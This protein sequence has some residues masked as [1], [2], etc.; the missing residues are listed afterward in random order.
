VV[1]V[2]SCPPPDAGDKLRGI[3]SVAGAALSHPGADDLLATVGYAEQVS[4]RPP[5]LAYADPSYPGEGLAV[6]G[7]P[8][9]GE[10]DHAALIAG[11]AE[12]DGWA[13]SISAE[14]LPAV[15]VCPPEGP[16]LRLLPAAS[17]PPGGLQQ[18]KNARVRRVRDGRR[19]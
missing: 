15:L 17:A 7:S 10:V 2:P 1:V 14:A 8:D 5:R 4:G 18:R 19:S 16:G 11:F 12:Y 9:G 3:R 6:S 13:L